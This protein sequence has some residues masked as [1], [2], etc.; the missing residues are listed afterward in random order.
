MDIKAYIDYFDE[1]S[2]LDRNIQF[3]LLEQARNQITENHSFPIFKLTSNLLPLLFVMFITGGVYL[4]FGV[5]IVAL[6]IAVVIGLVTSRVAVTE[7][8]SHYMRKGLEKVLENN[9]AQI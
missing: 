4:L 9:N 6:V 1:I 8:N 5:S 2:S 3:E 7:I